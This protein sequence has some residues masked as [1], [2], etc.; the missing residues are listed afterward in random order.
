MAGCTGGTSK[1]ATAAVT[2]GRVVET[3]DAAGSVSPRS[4]A[5]LT[6]PS[7]AVVAAV[8]ISEGQKVTAGQVLVQLSSDTAS[9]RLE[10]ARVALASAGSPSGATSVDLQAFADQVDAAAKAAFAGARAAAAQVSDKDA[11]DQALE[12]VARAERQYAVSKARADAAVRQAQLGLTNTSAALAALG[13]AQRQQAALVYATAQAAVTALTIRAPFSGTATLGGV[14]PGSSSAIDLGAIASSVGAGGANLGAISGAA[15][16]AVPQ[17]TSSIEPGAKVSS[18]TPIATVVDATSLSILANVDERDVLNVRIGQP[19]RVDLD[20]V[21][22]A[23]YPGRVIAVDQLPATTSG[24]SVAYRVRLSIAGGKDVSGHAAAK[25]RAGMSAVARITVATANDLP[26]VP[27]A[28]VI[29]DAAQDSV[30][31]KVDGRARRHS[32][33]LGPQGDTTVAVSDGLK[34]GDVVVVKGADRVVE[35]QKL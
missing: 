19:A 23:T 21:P 5:V 11:R 24:G 4:Q 13:N 22:G 33:Q 28:A 12:S 27:A 31:L 34:V 35:G 20:A 1:I 16:G 2:V 30:W 9:R 10:A 17:T 18:G 6:S 3:I 7:D 26:T 14:S 15:G 25:P 29:K 8:V 32:I